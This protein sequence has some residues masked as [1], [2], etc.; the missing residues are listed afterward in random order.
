MKKNYNYQHTAG[1]SIQMTYQEMFHRNQVPSNLQQPARCHRE[2]GSDQSIAQYSAASTNFLAV[3]SLHHKTYSH[4]AAVGENN[5]IIY[6]YLMVNYST[7]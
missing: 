6:N 3:T 4:N 2:Q 7:Q 1:T 5:S